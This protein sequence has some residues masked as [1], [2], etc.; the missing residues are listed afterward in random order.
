V[1]PFS[2]A[3]GLLEWVEDTLPLAEYLIGSDRAGGAHKR[4]AKPGE[5]THQQAQFTMRN[6]AGTDLRKRWAR[7]SSAPSTPTCLA[8][9]AR[10]APAL[11]GPAWSCRQ[12]PVKEV[13]AG[14]SIH[15]EIGEAFQCWVESGR[16]RW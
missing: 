3:A 11:K 8:H 7:A 6:A 13:Q 4:Y 5:I 12:S 9:P 2:P 14:I 1:V 16:L 15:A 10:D